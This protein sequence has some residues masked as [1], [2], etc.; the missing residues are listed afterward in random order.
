MW[1]KCRIFNSWLVN[2]LDISSLAPNEAEGRSEQEESMQGKGH[3]L[4]VFKLDGQRFALHLAAVDR[5]ER[6]VE[7]TPLPQIPEKVLGIVNLKGQIV[8]VFNVRRG[9]HLA[10]RDVDPRD[11][12]IFAHT[13]QRPVALVVDAVGEVIERG[14][15][16]IITS[17]EILPGLDYVE[18]VVKLED[19][20][21]MIHDLDRFLSLQEEA[22]LKEALTH[23]E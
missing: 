18:G 5:I 21:V 10:E 8:P 9:F 2:S 23:H 1:I 3:Q 16:D 12:L 14:D 11:Q 20:I 22:A 4:L 17:G 15:K 7:I 19:G 6:A 13:A